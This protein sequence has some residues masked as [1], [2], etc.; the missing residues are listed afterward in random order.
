VGRDTEKNQRPLWENAGRLGGEGLWQLKIFHSVHK[1][2]GRLGA[3]F[4]GFK[5]Q[6][7]PWESRKRPLD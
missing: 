1:L 2:L 7:S 4:G 6:K 3:R 5:H